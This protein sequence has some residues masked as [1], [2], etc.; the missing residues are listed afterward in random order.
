MAFAIAL[1]RRLA[2]FELALALAGAFQLPAQQLRF[3]RLA[4]LAQAPRQRAAAPATAAAKHPPLLWDET[5]VP[6]S[7]LTVGVPKET[8]EGETRV[9]QTPATAKAL[10]GKGFAVAVESGAGARASFSDDEYREAGAI[11]AAPSDGDG[12][13][14]AV[15]GADLVVKVHPPSAEEAARLGRG[16]ALVSLLASGLPESPL[17]VLAEA[18]V[19]AFALDAVPRT[20]P[21]AQAFDVLSPQAGVAGYRAVVGLMC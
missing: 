14:A 4:K 21:R 16:K 13:A 10:V 11:V 20:L 6:Y 12:L 7:D 8:L 17:E 1:M 9:A 3:S 15:W 19:A 18:G 5:P 2:H